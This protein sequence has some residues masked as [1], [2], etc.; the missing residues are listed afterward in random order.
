MN[1]KHF[2]HI[3]E[4]PFAVA[5]A[6]NRLRVNVR[7]C[8]ED[9]RKIMVISSVPNEGKS[10]IS[11]NLW[12][13]LAESGEKC[14][15]VDGDLRKSVIKERYQL[16]GE[17]D[18]EVKGI[19]HYLSGHIALKD[20]IYHTDF[21]NADI[22]PLFTAVTNPSILLESERFAEMLD[23]LAK[24]YRYVIV[25]AAPLTAVADGERIA[26]LCDGALMVVRAGDTSR[27]LLQRSIAQIERAGCP[28][29][30]VVLNR[31]EG[32]G[33]GYYSKYGR[34]GRYGKYGYGY[35]EYGK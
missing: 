6:L 21:P 32:K 23:E 22:V 5:E 13:L 29:I 18:G 20:A 8:G 35:G 15:F 31:V 16:G 27:K 9:I 4:L 12:K 19:S 34:Y 30:G 1:T 25:D 3:P 33:S 2:K 10:F 14:V 7:F 28:L 24:E 26:S 11:I 17:S